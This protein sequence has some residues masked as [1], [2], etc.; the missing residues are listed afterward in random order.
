MEFRLYYESLEQALYY[1]LLDLKIKFPEDSFTLVRKSKQSFGLRGYSKAYSRAMSKVLIHKNPDMILTGIVHDVEHV[2]AVEF[3]TAVFTKDHEQ[4]R[5]DNFL[6]PICNRLIYIKVSA[7]E[8]DS[9]NH[10][11]DTNYSPIEPFALCYQNRGVLAFHINWNVEQSNRKFVEK[12]SKYKSIPSNNKDFIL[13]VTIILD[14]FKACLSNDFIERVNLRCETI[15]PFCTWISKLRAFNSF[16]RLD[17]LSSSRTEWKEFEPRINKSNAFVL[18]LNRM[19]HAMDPERGMLT[20]YSTFLKTDS[21]TFISKLVFNPLRDSWYKATP[22]EDKIRE[23]VGDKKSF[24]VSDLIEF[25]ILGLSLPEAEIL[26]GLIDF[27][28]GTSDIT[29]WVRRNY[30]Y[31]NSAFRSIIDHSTYL[32]LEDGVGNHVFLNWDNSDLKFDFS[33]L[34]EVTCIKRLDSIGEDEVTFLTM[35][36]MFVQN[37]INPIS[38]SYPG[39]QSDTPVLPDKANGRSQQR[40]YVDSVGNIDSHLIFQENK[41]EFKKQ[42]VLKDINK[43]ILFREKKS[44]ADSVD[45]FRESHGLKAGP[46]VLGVGFANSST[47]GRDISNVGIDKVDYFFIV[48]SKTS[49]WKVFSSFDGGIFKV[50]KS[51]YSL[52]E[53]FEVRNSI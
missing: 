6:L 44:Y 20:H 11:G 45:V 33:G 31:F 7:T 19:G 26:K 42:E 4:Q 29:T 34:P 40:I 1:V 13:L 35:N 14:E 47:I 43:I 49:K 53:L 51:D 16:E 18:K 2:L 36:S 28:K 52:P 3:S 39:A 32:H 15:E 21:V 27:K 46:L 23:L 12:H 8:K 30:S 5:S 37:Q 25:L 22:K 17:R 41:G 38:V 24:S 50:L 9:G 48:D 10:G